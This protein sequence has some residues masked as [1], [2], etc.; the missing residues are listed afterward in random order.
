MIHARGDNGTERD[1]L[2]C[3]MGTERHQ[4]LTGVTDIV[5]CAQNDPTPPLDQ[6]VLNNA[7]YVVRLC[8]RSGALLQSLT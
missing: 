1:S 7:V 6:D 8:D 3:K 5:V 2:G 4:N